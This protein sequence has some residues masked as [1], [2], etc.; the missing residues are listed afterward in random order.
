LGSVVVHVVKRAR[1]EVTDAGNIVVESPQTVLEG[2]NLCGTAVGYITTLYEDIT[3]LGIK[4]RH[5]VASTSHGCQWHRVV[6]DVGHLV[7]A[8]VLLSIRILSGA[9]LIAAAPSPSTAVTSTAPRRLR[10]IGVAAAH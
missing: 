3:C 1:V 8:V 7:G 9:G 6:L 10:R 2:G 4:G 5:A